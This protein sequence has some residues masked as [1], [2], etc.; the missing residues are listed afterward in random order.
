MATEVKVMNNFRNWRLRV[1]EPKE[2]CLPGD[3]GDGHDRNSSKNNCSSNNNNNN[4]KK[5]KKK[6]KKNNKNKSN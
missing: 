5:K 4:N 3:L 2:M 6:K 1:A